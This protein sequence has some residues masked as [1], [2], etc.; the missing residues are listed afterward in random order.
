MKKT[1]LTIFFIALSVS[2]LCGQQNKSILGKQISINK[3]NLAVAEVLN[4]ISAQSGVFFSYDASVVVSDRQVN[5]KANNLTILEILDRLFDKSLFQFIEKE[6]HIIIALIENGNSLDTSKIQNRN[7]ETIDFVTISGKVVSSKNGNLLPF[8]AVSIKNSPFGTITN[9]DGEFILKIEPENANDTIIFSCLGYSPSYVPVMQASMDMEVKLR[10]SAFLIKE[11]EVN[12]IS[13]D[14]VLDMVYENIRS[15]YVTDL[16]MLKAFY[17]E[18]LKQDERYINISEAILEILKAPYGNSFREDMVRLVKNRQLKK[19]NPF[20]WVDFKLQGGPKTITQLDLVKTLET[21][22]D[23]EFRQFYKYE[24]SKVIWHLDRPVFVIEFKPLKNVGFHFYEGEMYV[25][26]ET[27]VVMFINFRMSKS[28]L[29]FAD[30]SLIK[31][32]P[33]GFKVRTNSLEYHVEYTQSRHKWYMSSARAFAEFKIKGKKEKLN[34]VFQSVSEVLV[35]DMEKSQIKRF[36]RKQAFTINDVFTDNIKEYD[37]NFWGNFNIIKP[38]ADLRKA[39]KSFDVNGSLKKI[40][41]N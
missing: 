19:F 15:N 36:P 8:V 20:K 29:R 24:I 34:S 9:I 5:I 30:R 25:D 35:T 13:S 17:R 3:N 28:S 32:K 10:P 33:R 31:K 22:I 7:T 23:P 14:Y 39:L 16:M 2:Y 4:I 21:F 37:A 41:P 26:R 12:A 6:D 27:F 1:F 11:I 40:D 38:D 18:V